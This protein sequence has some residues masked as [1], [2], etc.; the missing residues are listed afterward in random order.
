L[1]KVFLSYGYSLNYTR[2]GGLQ[3]H[4]SVHIS[5]ILSIKFTNITKSYA[6][7]CANYIITSNELSVNNDSN[8]SLVIFS[9]SKR[10]SAHPS[11]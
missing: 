5:K 3:I 2:I 1:E 7:F 4:Y 11:S 6:M 8:S 9:F 10:S